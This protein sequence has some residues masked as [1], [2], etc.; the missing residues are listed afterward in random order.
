MKKES[1]TDY[2]H[3]YDILKNPEYKPIIELINELGTIE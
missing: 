3:T 2:D 1:L